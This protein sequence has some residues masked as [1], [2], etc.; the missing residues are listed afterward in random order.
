M[1]FV[2]LN[3]LSA[4]AI[5]GVAAY[6]SI[7][8]LATIFPGSVL[9]VIVM[10]TVLEIGKLIGSVW[11]H[12]NWK[13]SPKYI[14]IYLVPA[15]VILSIIT[16]MGIFGF[17]SKSHIK[18]E[19]ESI[20]NQALIVQKIEQ[21][22]RLENRIESK[23]SSLAKLETFFEPFNNEQDKIIT[24]LKERESQFRKGREDF[25]NQKAKDLDFLENK[26][27]LL[28]KE[29]DDLIDSTVFSKE[30]KLN[31]LKE[32]QKPLRDE[33]KKGID[34]LKL[35]ISNFN[36]TFAQNIENIYNKI[37]EQNGSNINPYDSQKS[38]LLREIQEMEKAA[39]KLTQERF[40]LE[41]LDRNFE[42]EIGPVKYISLLLK[43]FFNIDIDTNTSVRMI[44]IILIFVFDPFAILLLISATISL[45]EAKKKQLPPD[46]LK[47]RE[48]FMEELEDYMSQGGSARMFLDRQK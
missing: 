15:V 26:V 11:L 24:E 43:D 5:S 39:E 28:D 18:H 10:G 12:K 30:S 42:A 7:I 22:D 20:Q 41:S 2:F 40:D 45:D 31:K 23:E 35:E 19:H 9:S 36:D 13:T 17:L 25:L 34:N 47:I 3:F 44:I 16:S 29:V 4:I 1:L 46:V 14:K 8:G 6:F 38:S 32:K 27:I 33:I 21:I 37:D 48:E